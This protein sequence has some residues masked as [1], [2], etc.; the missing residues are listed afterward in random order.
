MF[1]PVLFYCYDA[2]CGWCYGFSDVMKQV[3]AQFSKYM[4]IEVLS[5]GMI[6][7][8]GKSSVGWLVCT[9]RASL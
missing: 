7:P 4:P 6:F 9:S 5:G 8:L 2:Y 1:N 3:D